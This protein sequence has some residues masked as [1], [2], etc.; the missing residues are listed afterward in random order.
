MRRILAVALGL[1]VLSSCTFR[2]PPACGDDQVDELVRQLLRENAGAI[3][4]AKVDRGDPLALVRLMGLGVGMYPTGSFVVSE[5]AGRAIEWSLSNQRT[6]GINK[7]AGIRTCSADVSYGKQSEV[8]GSFVL[9]YTVSL[10]DAGDVYV[11]FLD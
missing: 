10:T 8:V 1:L 2:D 11:Q 7:D 4:D 3:F 9:G 6:S 5:E